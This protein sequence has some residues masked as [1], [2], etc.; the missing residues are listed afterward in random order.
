MCFS[1]FFVLL[2]CKINYG[3]EARKLPFMMNFTKIDFIMKD[4]VEFSSCERMHDESMIFYVCIYFCRKK[5]PPHFLQ[6]FLAAAPQIKNIIVILKTWNFTL[7][8]CFCQATNILDI[9]PSILR[10]IRAA[11]RKPNHTQRLSSANR[12]SEFTWGRFAEFQFFV[13]PANFWIL[14]SL[15]GKFPHRQINDSGG[16]KTTVFRSVVLLSCFAFQQL[17]WPNLPWYFPQ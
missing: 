10:V 13:A 12:V 9:I 8:F 4:F 14:L 15:R 7:Q 2:I 3:E 5:F 1:R 16:W 11:R 17:Y 6:C